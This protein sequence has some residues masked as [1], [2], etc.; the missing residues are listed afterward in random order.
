MAPAYR[1]DTREQRAAPA[2][3]GADAAASP[4]LPAAT[5]IVLAPRYDPGAIIP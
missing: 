3:A 5:A 2:R 4:V 1:D